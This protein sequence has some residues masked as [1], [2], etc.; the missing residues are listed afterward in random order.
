MG[1]TNFD[2]IRNSEKY[3]KPKTPRAAI[4]AVE[5]GILPPEAYIYK[6]TSIEPIA[7]NPENLEEL[8]RIL[9]QKNRDLET[10]ILLKS[11]LDKLIKHPDKEVALFAAES[12]NAIENDY[13][14]A[15]ENLKEG[16]DRKRAEL[17]IELAELNKDVNDLRIFYLGESFRSYINLQKRNEAETDDLLNMCRILIALGLPQQAEKIISENNLNC[18]ESKFILADIA[19]RQRSYSE[20]YSIMAELDSQRASMD[21][22]QTELIDF[23]MDK[24]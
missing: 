11:I 14:K 23:W 6:S 13:N 8:E 5:A 17:Y 4:K 7:D 10:N 9:G 2:Y 19:F 1:R 12:L 22:N 15:V 16:E 18:I 21:Y 3:F 24:E 20:L